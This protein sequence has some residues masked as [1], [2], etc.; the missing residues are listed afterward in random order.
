MLIRPPHLLV[1]ESD[2]RG[3]AREWLAHIMANAREQT[4]D[5]CVTLVTPSALA[6]DLKA[7]APDRVRIVSLTPDEERR[8]QR[9]SLIASAFARWAVMRRYL[10]RLE[11]TH[12]LFLGLDHLLLPLA[13]GLRTGGPRVSGILFRPTAHYEAHGSPPRDRAEAR[14]DRLKAAL[15]RRALR[16][17]ALETVFSLDPDFPPFAAAHFDDGGKVV[18]LPDP[19]AH[20]PTPSEQDLAEIGRELPDGRV[21][22]ALFG[23]LSERKG[24]LALLKALSALPAGVSDSVAVVLAGRVDPAIRHE[25]DRLLIA[26]RWNRPELAISLIDRW[27][28]TGE[29]AALLQRADV[30]L[31]PYQRFVGS[32]GVL[33]WAAATQTPVICQD[34]GLLGRLTARLHLGLAVDTSD[35]SALAAA[36][37]DAVEQGPESLGDRRAMAAFAAART[38]EQFAST[39][40]A[41]CCRPVGPEPPDPVDE[42]PI[43]WPR[44]YGHG[45]HC[46]QN[47]SQRSP[48]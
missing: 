7:T 44:S 9:P 28:T 40:L 5:F 32:S 11:A 46:G 6:D 2:A 29:I 45:A 24:P 25:L 26:V 4:G 41:T 48:G 8:C 3:H 27:L 35:P 17:P 37:A 12:G 36:I 10:K 30:V 19:A 1:F 42:E 13:C 23:E 39:L 18:T 21:V 14:R 16:N 20:P 22:F 15:V 47:S 33:N 38:P 43:P 34:Y 31:T